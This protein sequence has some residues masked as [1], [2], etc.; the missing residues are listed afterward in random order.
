MNSDSDKTILI[1]Y[2]QWFNQFQS[3]HNKS[4]LFY[5]MVWQLFDI[6]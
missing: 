5:D 3:I 1:W 4:S 6:I 2:Q